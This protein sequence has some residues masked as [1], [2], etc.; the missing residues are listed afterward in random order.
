MK[1]SNSSSPDLQNH[2]MNQTA[3]DNCSDS[4]PVPLSQDFFQSL[5]VGEKVM[6][7]V[8][9]LVVLATLA[10]FVDV[11]VYVV[12]RY[13]TSNDHKAKTLQI[14]SIFPGISLIAM[15][16][17]L[18]PK[19]CVLCEQATFLY[20]SASMY[21]F[22]S[23]LFV[24]TGG[25]DKVVQCLTANKIRLQSPP[26][27]CCCCCCPSYEVTRENVQRLTLLVA[28]N[29]YL[30]PLLAFVSLA[31]WL[32]DKFTIGKIDASNGYPYIL[33]L[34]QTSFLFGL[35]GLFMLF[36]LCKE[37]LKPLFIAPKFF[38]IQFVIILTL[39]QGSIFGTFSKYNMPS[40]RGI[41]SSAVR[42][43][44]Y[45]LIALIIQFLLLM[46]ISRYFYRRPQNNVNFEISAETDEMP[47]HDS[48]MHKLMDKMEQPEA[49]KDLGV[50]SKN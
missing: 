9:C 49:E 20:I 23:L 37:A 40:C 30:Q 25:K 1:G 4:M 50:E 32:D 29:A 44:T 10:V 45:Y 36:E 41:L 43:R 2:S 22:V 21:S 46:I 16:S 27:C 12:R 17:L 14:L 3:G 6:V 35:Y 7:V 19:S 38:L 5:V 24:Y 15:F 28:Q 31:L 39:L 8:S 47:N 13:S 11:A 48:S 26:C 33:I 18:I 42:G 34:S